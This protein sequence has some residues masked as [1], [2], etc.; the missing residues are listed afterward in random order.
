MNR[1]IEGVSE[2]TVENQLRDV[3]SDNEDNVK[4][5]VTAAEVGGV[6]GNG[7]AFP[8]FPAPVI[9]PAIPAP[10]RPTWTPAV[11]PT[12]LF[13]GGGAGGQNNT[14]TSSGGPGGGGDSAPHP[15]AAAQSGVDYTG[16][17][18]GA[19][20]NSSP[21]NQIPGAGGDGIVIIKYP[22]GYLGSGGT[23]IGPSGGYYYNVILSGPTSVTFSVV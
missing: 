8:A 7:A 13:G 12:G 17:G 23:R 1:N 9:E 20:Y 18:G 2:D 10:V 19:C 4:A 6:G 14:I 11:G 21:A 5:V 3:S 15:N 22:D 16:G